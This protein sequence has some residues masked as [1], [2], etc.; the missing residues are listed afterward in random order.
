[1]HNGAV[2]CVFLLGIIGFKLIWKSLELFAKIRSNKTE[3]MMWMAIPSKREKY[4]Y[5]DYLTWDEGER[6][7]LIA[8][9]IFIMSP[10]SSRR[11]QQVLRELSTAFSVYL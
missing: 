1:M 9:E 8:G 5:T 2:R 3:G 4:S 11:H 7:E 10:A 6:I